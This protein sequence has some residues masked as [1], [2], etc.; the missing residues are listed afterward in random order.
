MKNTGTLCAQFSVKSSRDI[1]D[2]NGG[3]YLNNGGSVFLPTTGDFIVLKSYQVLRTI[4]GFTGV[5]D[6]QD[7]NTANLAY[8]FEMV[9]HESTFAGT[10]TALTTANL[11]SALAAISGYDD[12]KGFKF[13]LKITATADSASNQ[14]IQVRMFTTNN[15]STVL[16][17]GYTDY[18]LTGLLAGTT[19]GAYDG[20][21]EVSYA[22]S[23]SGSL[24][25]QLP[26]AFDGLTDTAAIKIRALAYVWDD[27][28]AT[29]NRY[30]FTRGSLQ[31]TDTE[32]TVSNP[33]T[34]A[35]YT[36]LGT[37]AKIYDYAKYWGSLRA[38]L[39]VDQV[40]TKSGSAL[41]TTF[42]VVVDKTAAQ[43]FSVTGNTVTIKADAI[44]AGTITT[45][46]TLTTLNG[47]VMQIT[48]TAGGIIYSYATATVAGF[49]VGSRL[50]IYNVTTA[51]EIYN[52]VPG[53]APYV[54]NYTNGTG[55][56]AGDNVRVRIAYVNGVHA[57]MSEQHTTTAT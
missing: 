52:G 43:V 56:S 5:V 39:L 49:A 33:A 45:T 30:A 20:A 50:Q 26:Y 47:A 51:T 35:A 17:I 54:T 32:V 27:H 13:R 18:T 14:V 25:V 41:S 44:T 53:A 31:T 37:T 38:N 42:N 36:A 16:P 15:A 6:P 4:T 11:N 28:T 21:T 8:S 55:Y 19:V 23:A 22:A 48:Y 24:V 1:Y 57:H 3:A 10:Y 34:V 7:V 46:G 9:G 2:L 40:F 29:F 12:A